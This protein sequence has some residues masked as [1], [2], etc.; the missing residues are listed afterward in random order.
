MVCPIWTT[1]PYFY[2]PAHHRRCPTAA[3][4]RHQSGRHHSRR[5]AINPAVVPA[6]DHDIIYFKTS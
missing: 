3:A 4:P 1:A 5:R 6:I 2:R